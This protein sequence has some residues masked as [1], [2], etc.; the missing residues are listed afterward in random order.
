MNALKHAF[1]DEKVAGEIT[2][3]YEN[4]GANWELSVS[5]NGVGKVIGAVAKEKPGLGTGIIKALSHQLDAE[6]E[7]VADAQGTSVT[8]THTAIPAKVTLAA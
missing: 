4:A 8:I 1:P 5:D 6:V 7:T 2:V 3:A